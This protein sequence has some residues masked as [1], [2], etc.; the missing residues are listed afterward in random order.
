MANLTRKTTVLAKQEATYNPDPETTLS[1]STDTM[2]LTGDGAGVLSMDTT[3][4][5]TPLLRA[6]VQPQSPL[7]GRSTNTVN[8]SSY[9][10]TS[11]AAGAGAADILPWWDAILSGVGLEA[12]TGD[13]ATQSSLAIY[14]P[15]ATPKSTA[16]E[17]YA[18][19]IKH[20]VSGAYG[21]SLNMN[22]TAGSTAT[23]DA[24]FSGIYA[25]PTA[26]SPT[27]AYPSDNKRLVE[28]EA[29][30][31]GSYSPIVRSMALSL[32]NTVSE[33]GD[34]NSSYG[35]GGFELTGRAS[36]TLDLTIEVPNDALTTFN[37]FPELY[38]AAGSGDNITFKHITTGP[39]ADPL[40]FVQFD[41]TSPMLVMVAYAD[42][43]GVRTYNLQYRLFADDVSDAA[44]RGEEITIT[45]KRKVT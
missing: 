17:V 26:S 37:P 28:S 24:T 6:S 36:S 43:G 14:R 30:T 15:V 2:L 21:S 38:T 10:M 27:F 9:V 13:D 19:G 35:F 44:G 29:L 4:V 3:V 8:I 40:E 33:R 39:V 25:A 5:D 45:F 23:F 22:F 12:T 7:V 34:A 41:F 18:D 16:F 31:I 32:S 1:A 11:R 42:D 20:R